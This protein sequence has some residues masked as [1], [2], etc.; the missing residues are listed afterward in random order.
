ML[1][2]RGVG[3]P[4][5]TRLQA[6]NR[7]VSDSSKENRHDRTKLASSRESDVPDPVNSGADRF[8]TYDNLIDYP[9]SVEVTKDSD[10][11]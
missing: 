6:H 3:I 5:E 8:W 1:H 10:S 2:T 11:Q 7:R 4:D 9:N